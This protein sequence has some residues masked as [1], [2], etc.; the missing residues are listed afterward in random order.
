M[1]VRR[2]SFER[3]QLAIVAVTLA[4]LVIAQLALAQGDSSY[5]LVF[6]TVDGGGGAFSTGGAYQLSGTIGQ[7]DAG[8]MSGGGYVLSGGFWGGAVADEFDLYLPLVLRNHP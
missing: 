6:W 2:F 3:A 7:P 4:L 1:R 5:D 8:A